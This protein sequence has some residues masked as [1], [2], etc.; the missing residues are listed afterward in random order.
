ML[1]NDNILKNNKVDENQVNGIHLFLC[2]DNTLKR[3]SAIENV[4][5]GFYL[6][7]LNNNN[8]LKSNDAFFNHSYG[9]EGNAGVNNLFL[10]NNCD[11]NIAGGSLPIGLLC[12][13][14]P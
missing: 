2:N 12:A 9:F 13:P 5:N 7:L 6:E 3:N 4:L 11:D 8:N 14:Q 10:N 1:S